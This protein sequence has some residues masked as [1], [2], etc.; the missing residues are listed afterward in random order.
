M[1][2]DHFR[3]QLNDYDVISFFETKKMSVKVHKL[4]IL[5]QISM[6]CHCAAGASLR[7]NPAD[8]QHCTFYCSC[9]H[10]V[11]CRWVVENVSLMELPFILIPFWKTQLNVS[12]YDYFSL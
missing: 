2:T 1:T 11:F 6:V 7:T 9:P 3:T 10:I 8:S 5:P 4:R 12:D